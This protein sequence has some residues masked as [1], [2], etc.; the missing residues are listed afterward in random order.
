MGEG[1]NSSNFKI[2]ARRSVGCIAIIIRLS[3]FFSK[4]GFIL[5]AKKPAKWLVFGVSLSLSNSIRSVV[6]SF[7]V[8]LVLK[9][10][11]DRIGLNNP[12]FLDRA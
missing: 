7:E 4:L 1:K 12:F 11:E 10:Y 9:I 6:E 5:G 8:F 2:A 3:G